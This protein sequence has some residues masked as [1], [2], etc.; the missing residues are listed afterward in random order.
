VA[1]G[2]SVVG[3]G[4]VVSAAVSWGAAVGEEGCVGTAIG[5]AVGGRGAGSVI[6]GGELGV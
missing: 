5:G 3:V 4:T 6:N 1:G 2:A